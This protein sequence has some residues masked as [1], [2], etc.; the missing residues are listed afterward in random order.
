ML[1]TSVSWPNKLCLW[2][3]DVLR[4]SY[5]TSLTDILS[6]IRTHNLLWT[7][8]TGKTSSIA[9][10]LPCWF[11]L[12]YDFAHARSIWKRFRFIFL[13]WRPPALPH[14]LQCSTIG[15]LGL[16]RRVRDGYGCFPQTHRHQKFFCY[17]IA[18]RAGLSSL[19]IRFTSSQWSQ[20]LLY[21]C[22]YSCASW[23]L[24]SPSAYSHFHLCTRSLIAKQ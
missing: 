21:I 7:L 15:R 3:S 6:V 17:T 5:S 13:I 18:A 16:N 19:R 11:R 1:D 12:A 8:I 4:M 22:Q 10:A 14:R 9:T 24:R 20:S 2:G 23:E